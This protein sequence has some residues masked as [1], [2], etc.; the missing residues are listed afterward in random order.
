MSG[1]DQEQDFRRRVRKE[2]GLQLTENELRLLYSKWCDQNQT[3][4]QDGAMTSTLGK[5]DEAGMTRQ[6]VEGM[7]KSRAAR[8]ELQSFDKGESGLSFEEVIRK[9]AQAFSLRAVRISGD[10]LQY[11]AYLLLTENRMTNLSQSQL[12]QA[13]QYRLNLSLTVD[14]L[15]K[16]FQ[17]LD[18]KKTGLIKSKM[19][20]DLVLEAARLAEASNHVFEI[21]DHH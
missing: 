12:E 4:Q 6:L 14:N 16:I 5:I 9:I 17:R 10:N 2:L 13:C 21:K 8:F 20:I 3:G 19:L 11:K 18:P 1:S 15:E 7:S